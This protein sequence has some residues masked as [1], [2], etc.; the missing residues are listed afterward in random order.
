MSLMSM[1]NQR[2]QKREL[3][4]FIFINSSKQKKEI[5]GLVSNKP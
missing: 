2:N 3:Y 4:D 5:C 1:L